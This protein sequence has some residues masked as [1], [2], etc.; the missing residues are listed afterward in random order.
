MNEN[1]FS[2]CQSDHCVYFRKNSDG[3][4][5][6]LLLYVDYMLVARSKWLRGTSKYC[7]NLGGSNL[8]L[9]G[10]VD[11]DMT[12]DLDG[13]RSTTGYVFIVGGGVVSWI[14]K[15]QPVVALSTIEVEYIAITEGSKEMI[16][17]QGIL[18]ELGRNQQDNTLWRDS[19]IAI[20]LEN[21]LAFHSRT[22]HIQLR[23]HFIRSVLE[24]GSL[25]LGKIHTSENAAN[26]F[27]KVIS[28]AEVEHFLNF[29]WS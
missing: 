22:K 12:G 9:Q 8:S 10:F 15:L 24:D 19:Q 20:H 16:W 7:L 28:E 23:Y 4:F 26:M 3:D 25:K 14:L 5:I 6:I 18:E 27:T 13:G 29:D 1:D 2:R 17:L 21:N 11:S